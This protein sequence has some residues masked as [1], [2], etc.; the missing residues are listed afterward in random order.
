MLDLTSLA[1]GNA[2]WA[3]WNSLTDAATRRFP[4]IDIAGYYDLVGASSSG[5]LNRPQDTHAFAGTLD[6]LRGRHAI[7]LGWEY[8]VYQKGEYNRIRRRV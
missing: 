7:A 8:R 2:A 3:V 4:L 5:E 6:H 1:P